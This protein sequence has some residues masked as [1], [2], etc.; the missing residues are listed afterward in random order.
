[1]SLFSKKY[2]VVKVH[3]EGYYTIYSVQHRILW[4]L[5]DDVGRSFNTKAEAFDYIRR[6]EIDNLKPV[7]IVEKEDV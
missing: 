1:M 4:V 2:R 3:C 6:C 5:W 7:I